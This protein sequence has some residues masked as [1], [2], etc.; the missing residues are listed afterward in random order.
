MVSGLWSL[1]SGRWSLVAGRRLHRSWSGQNPP[2]KHKKTSEKGKDAID[3]NPDDPERDK[4]DPDERIQH[5]RNKGQR[6]A[7][8]EQKAPEQ[9][10][11]HAP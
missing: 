2:R 9:K 4:E 5:Q 1:V 11:Q 7:D 8:D 3:R 6:P 10:F